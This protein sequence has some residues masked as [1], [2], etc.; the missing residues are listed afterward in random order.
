M[1][2]FRSSVDG[3]YCLA[4]LIPASSGS[5]NAHAPT[6][7][8]GALSSSN[9]SLPTPRASTTLS[10]PASSL[11]LCEPFRCPRPNCHNSYTRMDGLKY[12]MAHGSCNFAPPKDLEH[13]LE[14]LASKPKVGENDMVT[15]ETLRDAESREVAKEPKSREPEKEPESREVAKEAGRRLGGD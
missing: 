8:S 10:R 5:Q 6:P 12:H 13:L 4:S 2:G 11:L 14:L 15:T 7:S 9:A 3:S 1:S